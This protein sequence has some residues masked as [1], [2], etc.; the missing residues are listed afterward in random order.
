VTDWIAYTVGVLVVLVGLALSIALHE[1]GHLVPAKRFGVKVTQYMVGFGPTAWSRRRGETEYGVKWLPLGGYI[2]MIGMFPPAPGQD[3]RRLRASSTGPLQALVADAR[4]AGAEEVAP[5]EEHRV[6]YR[7]S[8]PKKLVVM[9]GGPTM[10]LVLG[11]VFLGIVI[12]A[13]GVP[14]L[15]T[16]VSAVSECVL[17]VTEAERACAPG[18]TPAPAAAAG[19]RP[20]DV[21]VAFDGRPTGDWEA[22]RAG[23]RGAAGRTVPVV[24]ERD[25]KQVTLQAGVIAD[26]REKVVDGQVVT[27]PDGTVATE[28]VGFLGVSPSQELVTQPVTAVPGFVGET[29]VR[30]AG[31]IVNLPQRMVGVGQAAFGEAERDP[32]GPIGVVGVGRLSG[33]VASTDV[34]ASTTERVAVML[35]LLGSLNIALFVFNLVPLMPLDGGHVAGALWEGARRQ[36]ARLRGRADPGPVDI[37]RLLPLTYV[38]A[39]F[40]VAMSGLLLYADIVRPVTLGG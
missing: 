15:T 29:V 27:N 26:D 11:T 12:S 17:P 32:N 33:E 40:L 3:P 37:A 35:S 8:A 9:L 19:L 13:I 39:T 34:F 10:N 22:V 21:I 5:G 16:K 4:K 31:I 1:I 23:I 18:D 38:V 24:V 30:T 6:F 20:G 25:G 14:A 7:L 28:R 2:R 36:V